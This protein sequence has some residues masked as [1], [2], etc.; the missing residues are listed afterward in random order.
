MSVG[1]LIIREL[2][3]GV[4][5]CTAA[6]IPLATLAGCASAPRDVPLRTSSVSSG[7]G[8]LEYVRRQLEGAWDIERYEWNDEDNNTTTQGAEG[9]MTLDEFGNLSVSGLI[10]GLNN[11]PDQEVDYTG[12]IV[13]DTVNES[14]RLQDIVDRAL[15]DLSDSFDPELS[16]YYA[17]DGDT[18]RLSI[19][20]RNGRETA[21]TIWTRR[22]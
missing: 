2:M 22:N 21:T 18:L 6:V 8:S 10:R 16:R 15:A 1:Q 19:R 7:L 4:C 11:D 5:V 17:F 13:I 12:R 9:T 3:W 14:F 20:D